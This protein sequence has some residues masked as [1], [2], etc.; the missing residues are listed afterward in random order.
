MVNRSEKERKEEKRKIIENKKERKQ[1]KKMDK[2]GKWLF[3]LTETAIK[4][5]CRGWF[6]EPLQSGADPSCCC[7]SSRA[8]A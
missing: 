1:K 7:S 2:N 5:M 6:E 3:P 4:K 8:A